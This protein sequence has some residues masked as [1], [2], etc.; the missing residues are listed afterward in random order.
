MKKVFLPL[1]ALPL[2]AAGPAGYVYWSSSHLKGV[3]KKLDGQKTG[4]ERLENF[5][6]YSTM[7]VHREATGEAE[8]HR[9]TVDV[10]VVENGSGTLVVGGEMVNGKTTAAGE[11]RGPSIRG[12]IQQKLA[13]GDV[14][15]VPANTPHQ[16]QL[17]PGKQI[18]YFIVKVE[19]K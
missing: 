1:L 7:V 14:V 16:V 12:G 5:G 9:H 10:M 18:T 3:E 4:I 11:M 19:A 13:S 6:T 17:E 2:L 15:N 8:L